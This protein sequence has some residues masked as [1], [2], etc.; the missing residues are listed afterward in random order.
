MIGEWIAQHRAD[1][2]RTA[3]VDVGRGDAGVVVASGDDFRLR[4]V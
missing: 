1:A 2:L 4:V 3:L